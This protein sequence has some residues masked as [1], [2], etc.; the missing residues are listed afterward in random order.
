MFTVDKGQALTPELIVKAIRYNEKQK[1]IH[2]WSL[3][4]RYY[5]GL[6]NILNRN[7]PTATKNNKL[8]INHAQYITDS[9]VGY[10]LGNP[11]EWLT[12]DDYDISPVLDEFKKE[13]IASF[14]VLLATKISIFG[15]AYELVYTSGNEIRSTYVDPRNAVC[16]YDDSVEHNLLYGIVYGDDFFTSTVETKVT[17]YDKTTE[18]SYVS[19]NNITKLEG[20]RPHGFNDIPLIRYKNNDEELGDFQQVISLIDAYNILQSDRV[21]DKEQL[22]EAILVGYGFTL[23]KE[24]MQDLR[25]NR[26]IFGLDKDAKLEY[27]VKTFDEDNLDVLRKTLENDIHKISR[28]PDM[29]DENFIGNLSGVAL[30]YKLLPFEQATKNKE[31]FFESGLK[32]R[33]KL[34]NGYL[35]K[36]SKMREI[37]P[38]E[39]VDVVFKNYLPQNIL[40]LT[41]IINNLEGLVDKEQLISLLP[42]VRNARETLDKVDQEKLDDVTLE[43]PN[44]GEDNQE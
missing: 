27:L 29:N 3:L 20:K 39:D 8:V 22:V 7:K 16:V 12:A 1:R 32:E 19:V 41:Q 42:F 2:D 18:Y 17:V 44:Y 21:N 25:E 5:V 34:Y 40:E 38:I 37:I 36:L 11:C 31:R 6:H 4:A 23:E 9:F 33:F 24:Q 35:N 28:V 26:T 10:M 30:R 43:E 13:D 14:D 15:S